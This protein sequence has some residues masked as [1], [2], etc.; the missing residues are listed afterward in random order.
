MVPK[1][2]RRNIGPK[3]RLAP[4]SSRLS[5]V[6]CNVMAIQCAASRPSWIGE[7]CQQLAAADGT[8]NWSSA[9]FSGFM[10]RLRGEVEDTTKLG[11][12]RHLGATA[13]AQRID[14]EKA[15]GSE[16]HWIGRCRA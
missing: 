8:P 5:S 4:S 15:Q 6:A 10:M 3:R 11:S 9:S 13:D 16:I 2:L 7:R 1:H 14:P 12:V